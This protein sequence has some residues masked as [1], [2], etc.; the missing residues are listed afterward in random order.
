MAK[1]SIP[2][3]DL[4]REYAEIESEINQAIS[5]VLDR[6]VFILGEEVDKFEAAFSTYTGT[7][8]GVSVN[9]GSDALFLALKALG[10]GANSEVITVSH[11][12]VSTVDSI[13]R[14]HAKPV[15]VD[16]EPDTYTINTDEIEEKITNL[17]KAILPVH[18]YGHPAD[19]D[20]ILKIARRYGLSVVEDACQ[21]HGAEY[22]GRKVGCFGDAGCFSFYPTKNLGSYGDGGMVVT[23]DHDVAKKVAM[24]RN[25]GQQTKY[26]HDFV[27]LNSR[28]DELQASILRV[29]LSYLDDWNES[30]RRLSELYTEM[31]EAT[32]IITPIEKNYAKHV[33]YLFVVR[34]PQRDECQSLLQKGGVQ[35]HIHYPI[36]VH[37]QKAYAE[38]GDT[39]HLPATESACKAILS[40]PLYPFL[41]PDE[42]ADVVG[43]I[44]NAGC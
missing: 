38:I 17:T 23:D 44:K 29:K 4:R 32:N 25:Y 34:L 12:Y 6:G 36:P 14:C 27:G 13:V 37:K 7:K 10:I 18:L 33:Y 5:S 9:S 22:R 20:Q 26:H 39:T 8:Y 21:A 31:L 24:L 30:R 41:T 42:V 16:I 19:M 3:V 11:T 28:L 2:F 15:F 40:L 1:N 35:T 43:V